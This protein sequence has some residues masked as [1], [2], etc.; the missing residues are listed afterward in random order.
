MTPCEGDVRA[1]LQGRGGP[2]VRKS[3]GGGNSSCKGPEA[4]GQCGWSRGSEGRERAEAK[5]KGGDGVA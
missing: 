5:W 1:K 4:G 3:G 2:A